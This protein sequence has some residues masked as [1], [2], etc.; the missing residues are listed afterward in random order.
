MKHP[1]NALLWTVT[2]L[3]MAAGCSAAEPE[4]QS[5]RADVWGDN[6]FAIYVGEE[7]IAEDSVPYKTERSFN[8]DTVSFEIELPAQL[9]VILKDFKENDTG[10]EY[11]GTNRQQIGDGGF[12]AQFFD[13]GTGEL[14][15]FSN[16]AWRCLSVHRAPLNKSCVQSVDPETSCKFEIINEPDNWMAADFDDSAW[17]N[18]VEHSSQ[19]V[20]PHGGYSSV[21]WHP[22]VKLIWSDDLEIDNTVLCRTTILTTNPR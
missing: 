8:A 13:A 6:W 2:G 20:R 9:N 22:D 16:A 15:A 5:I 7:L 12:A 10:L 1:G 17:P 4:K 18:A 21:D 19:A 14:I 11:I 3:V